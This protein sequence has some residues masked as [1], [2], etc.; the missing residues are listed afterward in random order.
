MAIMAGYDRDEAIAFICKTINRKEHKALADQIDTLIPQCIDADM[1]FMFK[2]HVLD[3]DGNAGDNY[4]EDD[5][6]IEYMVEKLAAANDLTPEQ[7]VKL[8]SLVDDYMDCQQV[9]L[10]SKGLV[11]WG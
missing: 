6:A 2:T 1:E 10:E 11:E 3:A 4:Y 5:D 7:A 9:Y 8:A